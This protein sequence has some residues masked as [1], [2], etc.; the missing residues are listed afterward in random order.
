MK[1]NEYLAQCVKVLSLADYVTDAAKIE[2]FLTFHRLSLT[3]LDTPFDI[4]KVEG[5]VKDDEGLNEATYRNGKY[6]MTINGDDVSIWYEFFGS[7]M[8]SGHIRTNSFFLAL[9]EALN[10]E[11]Q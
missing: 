8:F 10:I 4:A 11:Q 2:M 7:Q 1:P 9:C 6:M 3:A 5:W